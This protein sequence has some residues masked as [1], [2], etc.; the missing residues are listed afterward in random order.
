MKNL[1]KLS[2]L[3]CLVMMYSTCTSNLE[4]DT[5][6]VEIQQT[7]MN[8]PCTNQDPATRVINNGTVSFNLFVLASDGTVLAEIPDILTNTTTS[9]VSFPEGDITFSIASGDSAIT[10]EVDLK[11]GTCM[12]Y[13]IEI[14][15]NNQIVSYNPT[16]L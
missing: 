4:E 11:M 12:A 8:D 5:I 10:D 15:S 14:D 16:N 6:D 13:E 3:L 1:L 7:L 2:A 9:W